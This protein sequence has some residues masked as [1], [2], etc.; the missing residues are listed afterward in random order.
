MNIQNTCDVCGYYGG[1]HLFVECNIC[2]TNVCRGVCAM[3]CTSCK[4]NFCYKHSLSC[5]MKKSDGL[6]YVMCE[7]CMVWDQAHNEEGKETNYK[8]LPDKAQGK[9]QGVSSTCNECKRLHNYLQCLSCGKGICYRRQLACS[10]RHSYCEAC[11]GR[12][13]KDIFCRD[14]KNKLHHVSVCKWCLQKE[15]KVTEGTC[16]SCLENNKD[17]MCNRCGVSICMHTSNE[18]GMGHFYC[19]QCS[20]VAIVT[21]TKQY[22]RNSECITYE[23]CHLCTL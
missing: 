8:K 3:T 14:I 6:M 18:C 9:I 21:L 20:A 19:Q 13:V 17:S 15:Y 22:S 23:I 2:H 7:K 11:V 1:G 5:A 10:Q 12:E 4:G 16:R